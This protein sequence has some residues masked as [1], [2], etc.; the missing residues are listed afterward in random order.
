MDVTSKIEANQKKL[1]GL[2][3]QTDGSIT[4]IAGCRARIQVHEDRISQLEE[5]LQ[6]LLDTLWM[7]AQLAENLR[8]Q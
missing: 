5:K 3:Q 8:A 2:Q 4:D 1:H 6:E 7:Q